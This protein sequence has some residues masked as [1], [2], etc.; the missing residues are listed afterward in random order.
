[1]CHFSTPIE[2]VILG[3]IR[4]FFQSCSII[5]LFQL[6]NI[7]WLV[8]ET[9]KSYWKTPDVDELASTPMCL[10]S[11]VKTEV[12]VSNSERFCL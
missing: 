8:I 11:K 10:K 7:L 6:K 9:K 1:M 12:W 4:F 3:F 2:F 5:P